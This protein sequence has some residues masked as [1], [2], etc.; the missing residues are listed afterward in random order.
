MKF[1]PVVEMYY[2]SANRSLIY[3]T[4]RLV[5]TI[6]VLLIWFKIDH[7]YVYLSLLDLL[8]NIFLLFLYIFV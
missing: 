6:M 4:G 8:K 5:Y 3:T 7:V 2:S 1:K